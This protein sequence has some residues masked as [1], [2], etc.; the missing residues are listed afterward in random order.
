[1]CDFIFNVDVQNL[2]FLVIFYLPLIF[3]FVCGH[4]QKCNFPAGIKYSIM[5]L[6]YLH[7]AT[8]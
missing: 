1:M 8:H 4:M 7:S 2:C 6:M 5:N 3:M